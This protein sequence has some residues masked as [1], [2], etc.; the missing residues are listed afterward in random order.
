MAEPRPSQIR[1]ATSVDRGGE[2][3]QHRVEDQAELRH[4]EVEL[5]LQRRHA[6]QQ[7]A[8]QRDAAHEARPRRPRWR[9]SPALARLPST[10][11]TARPMSV[12]AAPPKSIRWVGPQSVTSWP[13]SRCHMS[14]SGKPISEKAPQAAIRTPPSGAYQVRVMRTAVALGLPVGQDHRDVARG[15]DAEEAEEDEVVRRVGER[16]RVAALR[17]CGSRC[18][19]ASRTGRRSASR[20]SFRRARRPTRADRRRARS[21]T[22]RRSSSV[23]LSAA[24]ARCPRRAGRR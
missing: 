9:E 13:K 1:A 24:M 7:A 21:S 17:R 2:H 23:H 6:E 15:E 3:D 18:P 8:G 16:A 10:S 5:A 4:A 14:S 12:I 20:R 22:P 11:S 19:R